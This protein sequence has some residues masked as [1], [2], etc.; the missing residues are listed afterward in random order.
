MP[1]PPNWFG[2]AAFG[3][4][5]ALVNPGLWL[6]GLG[7]E[8]IYLWALSRNERFR[9]TVDA[10]AGVSDSTSRYE[11]L[12]GKPR[13]RGAVAPVRDRTRGRGDRRPAAAFRA[14][15]SQ[16]GDIRQMAWLHLKLLAA[17]ASF[18]EV[19]VGRGSRTQV[20]RRA[21][22]PLPGATVRRRHG[23]RTAAQPR[24]ATRGDQ[25]TP[26]CASRRETAPRTGG[27]G[28]RA[29][30]AAGVAGARAGTARHRREHHGAVAGRGVGVAQRGQS[31]DA[32]SARHLRRSR[33]FHG[34]AAAGGSAGFEARRQ[35]AARFPSEHGL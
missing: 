8:G 16:I 21:G 10:V 28:D 22:T 30:A 1:I 15:A 27:R 14:H 6:I 29:A 19:V 11:A 31:L 7:L 24:T 23:R 20:A 13:F 17:R 34:R 4:L 12:L 5:G 9:A 32:R 25:V 2:I 18:A 3:L 26:G 33:S 35:S